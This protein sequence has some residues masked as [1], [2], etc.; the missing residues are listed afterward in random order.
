M[1]IL[2][3]VVT[4]LGN[5]IR[6]TKDYWEYLIE[7]EHPYMI[8]K[9]ETVVNVLKDPD[10]IHKSSLDPSVYLYYRMVDRPYCVVA[11][12]Q[13]KN[14]GFLITAYPVDKVKEGDVIWK[15]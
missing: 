1:N 9:E 3:E 2:F 15:K 8:N 10:E 5:T 7:K 11:K 14:E 4:P 12:H 13:M 6:T